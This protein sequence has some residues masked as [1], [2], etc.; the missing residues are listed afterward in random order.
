MRLYGLGLA[1][2]YRQGRRPG[3]PYTSPGGGFVYVIRGDHGM[4][5]VGSSTNPDRR[6]AELQT[7]SPYRLWIDYRI[8]ASGPAADVEFAAHEILDPHR[9]IGEWFSVPTE[10]AI[11]A[12]HAAAF[13][14]GVG[15]GGAA[16]T[17]QSP[18]WASRFVMAG[19]VATP[20]WI[21]LAL[22][23]P[24][25]AMGYLFLAMIGVALALIRRAPDQ[26]D[27]I[28]NFCRW[29]GVALGGALLPMLP[30]AILSASIA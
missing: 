17:A 13:R 19:A 5:K 15:L 26:R 20:F 16:G 3:R 2:M 22:G 12:I 21:A 1:L 23:Y 24:A 8:A 29:M 27:G 10:A 6:L 4:T 9:G 7:G 18:K 11:A 25:I 30:A 14:L 28:G